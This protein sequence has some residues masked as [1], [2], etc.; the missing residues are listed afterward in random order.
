LLVMFMQKV[1]ISRA[2]TEVRVP[3]LQRLLV[4]NVALCRWWN[5]QAGRV[6]LGQ[7]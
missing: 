7:N 3:W 5:R 2:Q 1:N 6:Q 4:G